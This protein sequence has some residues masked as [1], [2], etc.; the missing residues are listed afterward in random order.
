MQA[1]ISGTAPPTGAGR[2]ALA[3]RAFRDA[4]GEFEGVLPAPG[5]RQG[6]E[7]LWR[8]APGE[9][10]DDRVLDLPAALC[11][12]LAEGTPMHGFAVH[13]CAVQVREQAGALRGESRKQPW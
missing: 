1:A 9:L 6:G 13:Q 11:E 12:V 3:R 7:D 8:A 4:L 2:N 5:S 10:R